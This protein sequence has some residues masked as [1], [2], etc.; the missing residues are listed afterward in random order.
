M[1]KKKA[2]LNY[3]RKTTKLQLHSTSD[4]EI[5]LIDFDATSR[6]KMMGLIFTDSESAMR[7]SNILHAMAYALRGSNN[8]QK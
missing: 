6:R 1:A 2:V 5:L 3:V 7:M 4:G 8:E